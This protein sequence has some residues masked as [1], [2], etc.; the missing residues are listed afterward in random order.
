[1]RKFF[2]FTLAEVLITL[3]I[4]GVVAALTLPTLISNHRKKV[5]S[6]QLKKAVNTVL[7][8]NKLML[9]EAGVDSLNDVDFY[10]HVTRGSSTTMDSLA[11]KYFNIAK[12]VTNLRSSNDEYKYLLNINHYSHNTTDYFSNV[13]GHIYLLST[14]DGADLF[15]NDKYVYIDVN[16]YNKRPNTVGLDFFLLVLNTDGTIARRAY[17]QSKEWCLSGG[18]TYHTPAGCLE[19]VMRDNWEITYY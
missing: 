6:T 16:G 1:M 10:Q 7:N 11:R 8:A 4:I 13:S 12:D 5:Y 18:T 15:F 3:G 9:A 14:A 2:G 17:N 19:Q